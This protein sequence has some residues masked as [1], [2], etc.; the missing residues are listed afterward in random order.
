MSWQKLHITILELCAVFVLVATFAHKIR[1]SNIN[2]YTD[3]MAVKS[4][5]NKQ[6]SRNKTAMRIVRPLVLA[7]VRYNIH[8][9]MFFVPGVC[10]V[11]PDRLSR[12]QADR[13]FLRCQGLAP[14]PTAV[15]EQIMPN[16]WNIK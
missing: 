5:L 16:N 1:N 12:F 7:L 13:E 8:L 4:I 2:F 9:R 14:T 3:N 10:N 6:S 15:P 11:I